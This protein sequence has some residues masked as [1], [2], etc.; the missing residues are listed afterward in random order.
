MPD[1]IPA[2]PPKAP[3][4]DPRLAQRLRREV[5]GD[6]LFTRADRGRY[7]TDASIYQVEPV[8]VV[9]PRTTEGAA[10]AIAI[11]REHGVPVLP[12]GGGT[13]QCGQTVNRALVIDCTKHLRRVLDVDA[14]AG[15]AVVEPGLVLSHLNAALKPHGLF[16]PVDPS[17]NAR[18]T[19]G[20]MAG[21]NS[22][23]AKSIRYGLMADNVRAIDAILADGTRHRFGPLP[24]V[25]GPD[26]PAVVAGLIQ[27]L[28]ALGAAEADE[29]AARFPHQLRRVGG[30]NIEVLT[31]GAR[32]ERRENLARLLVGSEGTL[33]FSAGLHLALQPL[34]P[35]K[36]MGI[37]Q[38]PTFRA[39]MEASRHL[40]TLQPEAV[41]LVDRT[42]IDLG[43][44]IPIYAPTIDRMVQGQPDS[45]LIVEF[46]GHEDGPLLAKLADLDA[47]MADLGWPGAVVR[48]TDPAFQAAIAEVREA[49][50]NIMMSMKGDG[51]PVSFIEDCAV[52]LDD[53]A[54]Y[55]E[56]LNDVFARHGTKGTWYAHASVGC[57]HV[58]P[59]LNM[60]DPADV[61]TMR[62]VAEECFALVR[63]YKGSHSGEHGDGIVRSEFHQ[64]MFGPRIV[65]AFEAVKD[66]FDPGAV[67]NP[68]RIVRPPR[69]DDRSLFRY[70][71]DYAADPAFKPS[72]DWSAYPGPQ[73]GMLAAVEM[74]N[75][76]GTCR[77]FDAG[78]MC[79]SYRVTREE[80]HLTR[81]R[82]NTLRL[83]LTGQLG[84]DAMAGDDVADALHL[85][86]S[87]KA[88]RR[89]CPTGVDMAKMKVEAL[90]ARAARHGVP[91]RAR[92]VAELPRLARI[93]SWLAPLANLR[94][95]SALLR[96]L[97]QR[98]GIAPERPL[99]AWSSRPFR[100]GEAAAP[101]APRGDVLLLA[102]TFNRYF[103]P[104]NLRAAVRVLR[105]AGFRAVLPD[106]PGRP[107]CC[108]RTYLS[109]GMVNRAREEAARTLRALAGPLPVVGLE[110]SCL[111][112]LRDEFGALLPGDAS[113]DLA[114]RALL[115]SEFLAK[116][117]VQMD[118]HAVAPR[119]H[120]HGHCHQKAFGA[121]PD[122]LAAL[123][124]VPGL[125]VQ[126]VQSSC[127]GMAGAFG[128]QAEAQ[129]ASRAMAEAGLL[130][131][132]RA[133]A[134]EDLIVADGTS[135]R[136]Q[137]AD[138]SG[139]QAVH[140]V[141]VL[142]RALRPTAG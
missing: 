44:G 10:A 127:C 95:R 118:L 112:T 3:L 137:I 136:H 30:Y 36:V 79:P 23:G 107:L 78:A 6:V 38:F 122:A 119:A 121:F 83:A 96:R 71:A 74:C 13:S 82:A 104:E 132:V 117:D 40:V 1:G 140:S 39:A 7:A 101:P 129:E 29:I 59:V 138:L 14:Q 64:E 73:G 93:V 80:A 35:R 11:A 128:Y 20:G 63:E 100:D 15:T 45:L 50:L 22:C 133:A 88:C 61:R 123:R 49:G 116:Q 70:S 125:D 77:K 24:D 56:R 85:C 4:G 98:I 67:L 60:K 53:L 16:F 5:D 97:G 86:V 58:R 141:Q 32:R 25:T 62:A 51:K 84:A 81:G 46:H 130:P 102:D 66:A 124:R 134:V 54:D 126:P 131:A 26:V 19:L 68:N 69:M 114:G 12:R 37:C 87:C 115:L 42:M 105:A 75:N 91:A 106:T 34:L 52:G 2:I 139:R 92:L 109:A 111:L 94:N 113:A 27:R 142:D 90:A 48:A 57:L 103:E 43:R 72:L 31:P 76:N 21:N 41:E 108:G 120:V 18:C 9:V 135:C 89:E 55:T 65:R 17:T 28:R 8:G 33:A 99:P 47:M 110:P